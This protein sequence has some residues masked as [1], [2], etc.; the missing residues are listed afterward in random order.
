M[1]T[2]HFR[3]E[4]FDDS[5]NIVNLNVRKEMYICEIF[6]IM[7]KNENYVCK[8]LTGLFICVVVKSVFIKFIKKYPRGRKFIHELIHDQ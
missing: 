4:L 5:G 2:K 1:L 6:L 8:G 7:Y 3:S